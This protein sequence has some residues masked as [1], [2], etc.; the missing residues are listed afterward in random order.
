[1][2]I[3]VL[4]NDCITYLYTNQPDLTS[5]AFSVPLT[6]RMTTQKG[7]TATVQGRMVT[8]GQQFFTSMNHVDQSFVLAHEWMHYLLQHR[9]LLRKWVTDDAVTGRL[10]KSSPE[11]TRPFNMS[12]AQKALDLIINDA[13]LH[14]GFK[15]VPKPG[16]HEPR[17]GKMTDAEGDVYVRLYDNEPP[18]PDAPPPPPGSGMLQAAGPDEEQA[19]EDQPILKEFLEAVVKKLTAAGKSPGN[20]KLMLDRV[21]AP[22]INWLRYIQ[23]RFNAVCGHGALTWVPPNRQLFALGLY[24]ESSIGRQSGTVV[25]IVD[26]SGSV[27]RD[28]R[29]AFLAG[30]CSLARQ[31]MP[32]RLIVLEID[33]RVQ[34]ISEFKTVQELEKWAEEIRTKV[35]LRGG[36]GTDMRKGYQWIEEPYRLPDHDSYGV[37]NPDL[38]V[39]LTDGG[40]PWPESRGKSKR[41]VWVSTTTI[42]APANAGETVRIVV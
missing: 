34:R 22:S 12:V 18:K 21:I 27:G 5:S 3:P 8:C 17:M 30:L 33:A 10:S 29:S 9:F 39:Y 7:Y 13:L 40:T 15:E 41:V 28:E 32:R 31:T 2:R 35:G 37:V 11:I 42:E 25:V 23:P 24:Q 14:M 6:H 38:T 4:L 36:G 20:F 19:P 1:M 26:T 16:S